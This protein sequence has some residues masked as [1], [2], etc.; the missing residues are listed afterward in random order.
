MSSKEV[1]SFFPHAQSENI[2]VHASVYEII[3]FK[4][5]LLFSVWSS[6]E[7]N[8]NSKPLISKLSEQLRDDII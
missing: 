6:I 5:I 8:Y 4:L 3:I 1:L 7:N 2:R